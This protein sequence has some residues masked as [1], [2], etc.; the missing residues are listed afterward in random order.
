MSYNG[1]SNYETWRTNLEF[2]LLEDM[3][4]DADGRVI[5]LWAMPTDPDDPDPVGYVADQ[6]QSYVDDRMVVSLDHNPFALSIVMDWLREVNW[7][8]IAQHYMDERSTNED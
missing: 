6:M 1:W 5:H 4:Y 8:E 7:R 3:G 2:G